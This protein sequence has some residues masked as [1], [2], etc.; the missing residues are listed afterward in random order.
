MPKEALVVG[1]SGMG[2][3]KKCLLLTFQN[4]L[5]GSQ[6][7]TLSY[8]TWFKAYIVYATCKPQPLTQV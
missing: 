1:L 5:Q 2:T 7:L 4:L 8:D 6:P 3:K